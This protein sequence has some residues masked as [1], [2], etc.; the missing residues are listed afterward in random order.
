MFHKDSATNG[1]TSYY[2]SE[3]SVL[4][5]VFLPQTIS[6][7]GYHDGKVVQGASTLF[8]SFSNCTALEYVEFHSNTVLNDNTLNKGG[9]TNCSSLKAISLP[10]S[11]TIFGSDAL[12]GCTSLQ[13]VYLPSSLT[14]LSSSSDPFAKSSNIYFVNEPFTM[15]SASDVPSKPEVYCLPQGLTSFG[16]AIAVTA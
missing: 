3:N 1:N 12:G 4:K 15:N 11:I 7:I 9:F 2:Y 5:A 16:K 10:D 8:Y 13:A 6:Q 14:S